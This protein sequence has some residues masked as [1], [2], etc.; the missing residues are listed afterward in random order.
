MIVLGITVNVGSGAALMVNGRIVAA[1]SEERYN[2]KKNYEGYP[3]RAI[4]YVLRAGA[5][6]PSDVDHV[7][8]SDTAT[9]HPDYFLTH[10]YSTFSVADFI[11]EQEEFW[12]P[13]IYGGETPDFLELFRDHIDLHQFP[14]P[15]SL[16]EIAGLPHFDARYAALHRLRAR[17]VEMHLGIPAARTVF[18][19]HHKCHAAYAACAYASAGLPL[20]VCTI[21]GSGDGENATVWRRHGNGLEKI[22]GTDRL[23]IGRYYRHTTLLLGMR[24]AEHEFKV[25]GLAPYARPYHSDLPFQVFRDALSVRDLT[26]ES[27]ESPRDSYFHFKERL[28][29]SRFDGIAGGLQRFTEETLVEWIGGWMQKTGLTRV[30]YSGGVSM[31]VKAN[32][33]ILERCAPEALLIPGTGTDDSL[34]IGACYLFALQHGQAAEPLQN[35]YLGDDITDADVK[36]AL[37]KIDRDRYTICDRTS[38]AEIARLLAGGKILGRCVGRMEFGARALGNRSL[39]ADPRNHD[40]VRIINEKI[41]GRDFWMPFA[42]TI[43]DRAASRYLS[44][45][46]GANYTSMSIAAQSTPEGRTSIPAALHPADFSARPHILE[47]NA[48]PGYYDLIERFGQITGVEALLNTSLNLHGSPIVRTLDDAFHVLRNSA[49]DGLVAGDSLILRK[50]L[51]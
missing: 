1:A 26:I 50:D 9:M 13:R 30:A 11:R 17:M 34:A 51:P 49:I 42:P 7:A 39:L 8:W 15:K 48:N 38:N 40:V 36:A 45:H 27:K 23:V 12:Y 16:A 25:M 2:G 22:A 46:P 37:S 14:G 47:R 4:E 10:R 18:L 3:A 24:M 5:V 44:V 31:N 21:D 35:M 28:K 20:L 32:L 43:L 19:N 33:A 29:A 6:G 41:K